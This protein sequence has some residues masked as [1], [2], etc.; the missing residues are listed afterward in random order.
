MYLKRHTGLPT[1]DLG[2]FQA[3]NIYSKTKRNSV[4]NKSPFPTHT[5]I[6]HSST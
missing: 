2:Q 6:L 1:G 3:Y 5:V 4:S